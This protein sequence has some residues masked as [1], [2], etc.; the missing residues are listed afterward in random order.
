MKQLNKDNVQLKNL[1][2]IVPTPTYED[3]LY[4]IVSFLNNEHRLDGEFRIRDVIVKTRIRISDELIDDMEKLINLGYIEKYN[5]TSYRV[6]KHI[7]E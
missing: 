6:L 2:G 3:L 5:K 7:W 4:E 1:L